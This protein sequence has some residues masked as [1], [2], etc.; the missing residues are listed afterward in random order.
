MNTDDHTTAPV[1]VIGGGITGL[2]VAWGLKQRH[3]PVLLAER[4]QRL[5]GM[6]ETEISDGLTLEHGPFSVLVRSAAFAEMIRALELTPLMASGSKGRGRF[7][8]HRGRLI[9]VPGSP[10]GLLTTPLLS[11]AGRLRLLGGLLWSRRNQSDREVSLY[12]VALRRL[13][14]EVADRMVAAATMGIYAAEATELGFE[15]CLP[16]FAEA[17]REARSVIGM[18][19]RAAKQ[20]RQKPDIKGTISFEGGLETL[21]D[22]LRERLGDSVA[23]GCE[24]QSLQKHDDGLLA[25]TVDGAAI[26]ARAVVTTLPAT[27]TASLVEPL[28]PE[29]ATEL[30][31]IQ[32]AGL[33]VVQAA[34]SRRQFREVP[35]GFG[36]LVPPTERFDL[37][38][39]IYAGSVFPHYLPAGDSDTVLLR[40]MLG[41]TRHRQALV[42]SDDELLQRTLAGLDAMFGLTGEPKLT[43]IRRWPEAIPVYECG[44][45]GR[46]RRIAEAASTIPEL[47]LAGSWTGGV[48]VNDRVEQGLSLANSLA[49]RLQAGHSGSD[50][51]R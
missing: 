26:P 29:T 10:G 3:V 44:H 36:F 24:I 40:A 21:V 39:V 15:A 16:R 45:A 38:G 43:R 11:I 8:L 34:F 32:R 6:I 41:G 49:D 2:S 48:G 28:L 20:G 35:E 13:G 22:R 18:M 14:E 19:R 50:A 37:L 9:E 47:I 23:L 27:P 31:M 51:R 12:E 33:V 25:H 1:L 17:D 42:T 4:S 7:V 46:K 30:R 5:G